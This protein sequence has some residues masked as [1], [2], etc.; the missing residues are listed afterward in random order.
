MARRTA[1]TWRDRRIL[2]ETKLTESEDYPA[3]PVCPGRKLNSS[4]APAVSEVQENFNLKGQR[5]G[6]G[7]SLR[8]IPHNKG[9][10]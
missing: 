1:L 5:A 8:G 7:G 2:W 10:K 4:L 9:N 3:S 6:G